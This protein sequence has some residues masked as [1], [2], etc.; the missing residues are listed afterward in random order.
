MKAEPGAALVRARLAAEVPRWYGAGAGLTS[1]CA[2]QEHPWSFQFAVVVETSAGRRHLVVKVPRWEEAPTLEAAL[3]AGPQ[4]STRREH[5]TLEAIADAV[6]ASGDPGLAAV[7]PVAYLP[8]INAVVTE[9]LEAGPLRSRLGPRPGAEGRQAAVLR[10][11][12]RWLRLYHDRVAG[13][14]PGRFDGAALALELERVAAVVARPSLREALAGLARRARERDGVEAVVGATH[15]DFNLANVLVTGDG[16]VAVLDPNLVPGP[17]LQDAAKLLTDL[18]MRRA[19][20][21]ARGRVG[22]RG[23]AAAEAAFLEGYGPADS[24]LLGFL[25]D[26]AAARRGIEMEERLAG[27]PWLLRAPAQAVLLRYAVAESS[28]FAG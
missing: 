15:G 10:R 1:P 9:R 27:R 17:L 8:D 3:A 12:G 24:G 28:R 2:P 5:A 11:A 19:R 13:A 14:A 18:R 20:A 6:G 4:E 26:V 25:R 7:A 16:R 21:V 22:R 23:L